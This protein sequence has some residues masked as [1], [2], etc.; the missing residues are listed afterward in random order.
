M[1]ESIKDI[2]ILFVIFGMIA[3]AGS[4]YGFSADDIMCVSTQEIKF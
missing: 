3:V 1:K 2:L 4:F